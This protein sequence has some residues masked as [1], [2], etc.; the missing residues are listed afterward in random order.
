MDSKPRKF[1]AM[2]A[3]KQRDG[4]LRD[5]PRVFGKLTDANLSE[6]ERRSRM[7]NEPDGFGSGNR[8]EGSSSET[9]NPTERMA[10]R[11]VD[12]QRKDGDVQMEAFKRI[13]AAFQAC[14]DAVADADAAWDLIC[15]ITDERRGREVTLS[16]CRACLRDDVPG[17]GSDRIKSGY[18]NPCYIAWYRT[19]EG[20]GRQD[21]M[22]FELSRRQLAVVETA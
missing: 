15:H 8:G 9:S 3:I 17:V 20:T 7:T 10:L 18:C 12:G 21:R 4:V 19:D 11:L 6:I 16:T 2:R 14:W 22:T 5:L 1:S 13:D